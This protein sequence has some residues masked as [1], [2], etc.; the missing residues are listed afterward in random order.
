MSIGNIIKQL[1]SGKI[2]SNIEVI[3]S[4][5][6]NIHV[7]NADLDNDL[8][9]QII[10]IICDNNANLSFKILEHEILDSK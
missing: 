4:G 5:I 7:E 10:D 9:E 3:D 6:T 8:E 2:N 1:V